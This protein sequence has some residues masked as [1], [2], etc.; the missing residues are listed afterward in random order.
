[1][2][3]GL[4]LIL[5][6]AGSSVPFGIPAMKKFVELF[7]KEIG[8]DPDLASLLIDI[9]SALN[10]SDRLI[11]Y[12]VVFDLE[13]LMV[14]LQDVASKVDKPISAPTFAFILSLISKKD[15][16]IGEYNIRSVRK[17]FGREAQKLLK[18]LQVFIFK[19]CIEPIN[20]GQ[21]ENDGFSFLD[22]FYGPLFITID[23]SIIYNNQSWVFTTNW[24]LCLKQWLEY[25]RIAFED[26]TQL[27]AQRK[28]VLIPKGWSD[29][30]NTK[31]VPL[32]G[33]F[34]LVNCSRFVSKKAYTEI[35][36]L[37]NPEVYFNGNPSEL[38]KAFIVYPLEAVGYD[39]TIK[40][41]Y[42][43]MLNLLKERLR[44]ENQIF[45]I[46][47]SF[48]DSIIA[49]IFDEVVREKS[50]RGQEKELKILLLDRSPIEVIE[51]LKRQSYVNIANAITPIEVSFPN[52]LDYKSKRNEIKLDVVN[53]V[54]TLR[55]AMHSAQIPFDQSYGDELLQK[56]GIKI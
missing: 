37:S 51:N 47:F 56:Y 20:K 16:Q 9:E 12:D 19:K 4:Q 49:S 21:K 13:S 5:L 36:K 38:S 52:V 10:G 18:R 48:R 41:P 39:Q 14:V 40:S 1:M 28:S 29:A 31:V 50:E 34:D 11:G 30:P 32:H 54:T 7:K 42:L 17:R 3:V 22:M 2:K 43:D 35:Q 8:N 44:G 23:K 45:V 53:M 15:K 33:C 27:D 24:D 46:G 26:G 25:A 6:G 55:G